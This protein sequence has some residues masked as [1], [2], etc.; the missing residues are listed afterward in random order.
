MPVD[1]GL[2]KSAFQRQVLTTLQREVPRGKVTT[3]GELAGRIGHPRVARAAGSACARNPIP[4]VLPCHRVV[5]AGGTLGNYGG[6]VWRKRYLLD[7]E[8]AQVKKVRG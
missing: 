3:Y 7:I 4:I 5:P 8:G 1:L 6:E 2:I